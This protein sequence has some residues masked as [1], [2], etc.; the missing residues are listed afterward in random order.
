MGTCTFAGGAAVATGTPFALALFS[1]C[2]LSLF[3]TLVM[4]LSHSHCGSSV[5]IVP[6]FP[7]IYILQA[8]SLLLQQK[9]L[10]P[11]SPPYHTRPPPTP[12]LADYQLPSTSSPFDTRLASSSLITSRLS[13]PTAQRAR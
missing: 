12:A 6:T 3:P 2:P 10:P 11:S 1:S 9:L 7:G 8:L 4:S 5:C 13:S